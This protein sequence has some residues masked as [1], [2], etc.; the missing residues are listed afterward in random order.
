MAGPSYF[1]I[2]LTFVFHP[3]KDCVGPLGCSLPR[4]LVAIAG[5]GTKGIM[6]F[7]S[8]EWWLNRELGNAIWVHD[9]S[10]QQAEWPCSTLLILSH[11]FMVYSCWQHSPPQIE[12]LLWIDSTCPHVLWLIASWTH[13]REALSGSSFQ[14]SLFQLQRI[15]DFSLLHICSLSP[16]LIPTYQSQIQNSPAKILRAFQNI[17]SV[18]RSYLCVPLLPLLHCGFLKG[19]ISSSLPQPVTVCFAESVKL[20]WTK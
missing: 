4:P 13:P 12:N 11:H 20:L 16:P 9:L 5:D 18:L 14:E 15:W 8:E 2:S 7:I 19:E 6:P 10:Q 17:S 1:A 3:S